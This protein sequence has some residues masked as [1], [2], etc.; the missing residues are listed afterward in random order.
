MSA[1]LENLWNSIFTPGATPTLLIATNATFAALQLVLFSLL[2]ATYSIH[3]VVLSFLCGG[4][5]WAINWFAAEL[6]AA[7]QKEEEAERLRQV[8]RKGKGGRDTIGLGEGD[9]GADD[10]GTE[11]EVE[12]RKEKIAAYEESPVD[13][14]ARDGAMENLRKSAR[15][16][17]TSGST[18]GV[19]GQGDERATQR[20]SLADSQVSTDS[21]WEKVDEGR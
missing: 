11:T 15:A 8:R 19:G 6:A 16:T 4:L 5:W 17:M 20:R 14:K 7:Q 3:F 10:E 1:F 12:E 13:L 18:L 21:E 2:I 9:S